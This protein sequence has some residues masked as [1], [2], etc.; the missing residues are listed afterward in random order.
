MEP[1][2]PVRGQ[3]ADAL[4]RL[5]AA[6]VV[7]VI[8]IDDVAAARPLADLL[9][10]AGLDCVEITLRTEAA[11]SALRAVA[12]RGD[13]L[14]G[15]GTVLEPD[16]VERCVDAGARFI[17]SPGLDPQVVERCQSLGVTVLPGVATASELLCARRRGLRAVKFF[18]AEPAGG[19]PA[20]TA[21]AAAVPDLR[22]MPTGGVGPD[23]LRRYLREPAVL[24]VG[25]SW[26]APRDLLA[27]R[28]WSEIGARCAHAAGV[29]AESGSRAG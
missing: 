7:P 18:P 8:V 2:R 16:D 13:L 22:F 5:H 19:L 29:A 9:A 17:V 20:L 25:G 6:G 24:A 11:P 12:E 1:T 10:G 28:D 3:D 23:N 4:A 26:M 27:A 21:L 14:V 15:A